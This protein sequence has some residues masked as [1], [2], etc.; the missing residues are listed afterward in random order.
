[1]RRHNL[2]RLLSLVALLLACVPLV[3]AAA[4]PPAQTGPSEHPDLDRI[5]AHVTAAMAE[6]GVP[7]AALAVVHDS[8]VIRLAGY[9]R[10]DAAGRPVTPQTPFR[11]GSLTKSF[12]ALAIMQLVEQ[13]HVALDAPVQRYLP[14][15][16]LA[17]PQAAAQITVAQL[18]HQT[19]GIPASVL[20]ETIT[21]S[22]LSLEAY[23]RRL[24][25]MTPDRPVGSS[26]AY[27]NANYN[28]LGLI[29]ERVSGVSYADYIQQNIL[30]PLRMTNSFATPTSSAAAAPAQGHTWIFG[31]SVAMPDHF[32]AANLPAGY[33]SASVEDLA[34]YL[35]AQMS[36]GQAAPER[37]L[38][39]AGFA[40][41]H[42]A[43]PNAVMN[44][45]PEL[46]AAGYGYGMG[47]GRTPYAG[48]PAVFHNGSDARFTTYAVMLENGWG[49]VLLLN[50]A[51]AVTSEEPIETMA[52]KVTQLLYSVE[53]VGSA[54]TLPQIYTRYNALMAV[55]SLWVLAL[56]LRLPAWAR[57]AQSWPGKG[58]RWRSAIAGLRILVEAGLSLTAFALAPL[59]L[60]PWQLAFFS[61]PDIAWW[62]A[63]SATLL[64]AVGMVRGF[65]LIRILARPAG[66]HALRQRAA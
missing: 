35:I 22:T 29:V 2:I 32:S 9:G 50:A 63:G 65:L 19:S 36:K 38:S 45:T 58:R 27:S 17:D 6:R 1:M 24:A 26:F 66:A 56:A 25:E 12:T 49:F 60:G 44:P 7:G 37:V 5:E 13:G 33:I 40:L 28:T 34:R 18:L 43:G 41:M 39:P 15:F 54:D 62:L 3:P 8:E 10:A 59:V 48:V 55:V 11:I 30:T 46:A 52:Q 31:Q 14:W 21:D 4:T 61:V 57:K 42:R 53:P 64:L 16:R 23:V 20:D 51:S 47:W